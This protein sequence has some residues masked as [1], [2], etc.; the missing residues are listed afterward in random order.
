[1]YAIFIRLRNL[2]SPP[3]IMSMA[4]FQNFKKVQV[5]LRPPFVGLGSRVNRPLASRNQT[6]LLKVYPQIFGLLHFPPLLIVD[7]NSK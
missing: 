1:M 6:A 5:K 2:T 3:T 4:D 7:S